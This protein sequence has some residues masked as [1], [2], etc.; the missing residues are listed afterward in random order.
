[1][2]ILLIALIPA[3]AVIVTSMVTDSKGWTTIVALIAAAVGVFSG[4]PIYALLD[5]AVVAGAYWMAID[6]LMSDDRAKRN[7]DAREV[8]LDAM[9][10]ERQ[11][12]LVN[13]LIDEKRAARVIAMAN[14]K[15]ALE[16]AKAP[17]TPV[18]ESKAKLAAAE[19][20]KNNATH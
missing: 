20:D 14:A 13:T 10:A 1:M 2:W 6:S 18:I 4:N 15:A 11:Q 12:Q 16:A 3:L 7:D 8:R 9:E 17:A 19:T 5:F